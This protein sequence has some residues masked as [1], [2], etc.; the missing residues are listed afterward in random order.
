MIKHA[1][2]TLLHLYPV[3]YRLLFE[4]EMTAVFEQVTGDYKSRGALTYSAFLG[5]EFVGLIA[6]AFSAWGDEYMRTTARRRGLTASTVGAAVSALAVTA[7][8][9]NAVYNGLMGH[10]PPRLPTPVPSQ[11]PLQLVGLMTLIGMCLVLVSV[12]SMAF[13]WN[14]RTIGNR[15]GRLKPVWMP[16]RTNARTSKRDQTLHRDSGRQR[17]Q[18]HRPGR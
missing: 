7:F 12:L 18:L 2:E 8:L 16:G 5:W 9:Q 10:R 11:T 13:V 17:R 4:R 6:G 14:M 3:P 1:Y 15:S